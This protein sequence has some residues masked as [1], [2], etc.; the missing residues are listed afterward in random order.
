MTL[1]RRDFVKVATVVATTT[2]VPKTALA[3]LTQRTYPLVKIAQV[4]ALKPGEPVSF[5]YPDPQ[6]LSLLVKLG[7]PA[8]GGVGKEQDIVAFSSLCTHR[9]CPVRYQE[10]RFVCPCHFSQFDP[11]VNGQC[12][13]GPATEYLPQIKLRIEDDDVLAE[14]IDGLIWGRIENQL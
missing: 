6:A 11:A 8:L 9:G 7:R 14:G 10:S 4:S 3:Q 1:N 5:A 2:G 13:Q 12:F